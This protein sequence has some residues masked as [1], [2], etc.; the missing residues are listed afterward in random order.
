MK[1]CLVLVA[2]TLMMAPLVSD[3]AFARGLGG[4]GMRGGGGM[5]FGGGGAFRGGGMGFAGVRGGAGFAGIRGGG[6]GVRTAAVGGAFRG[7]WRPGWGAVGRPGLGWASVARP[8]WGVAR[9]SWWRPGWGVAG[10]PWWRRNFAWGGGG[11]GWGFPLAAGL[12]LGSYAAY[13]YDSNCL[14]WN[15]FSWVNVCY[16]SSYDYG[17]W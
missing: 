8:G 17:Y 11:W 3:G 14:A 15:G 1:R 12:A 10:R 9:A 2:A 4:G 7:A 6:F 13:D 5:H 16:Q